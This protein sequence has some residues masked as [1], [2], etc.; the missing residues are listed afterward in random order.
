MQVDT[1][2]I[3]PFVDGTKETLAT[4]CSFTATAGKP[5]LKKSGPTIEIDIA[6]VIGLTS[7]AFRGSITISFPEKVF[8]SIMGAM[9]GETYDKITD[10]I[11]DGAAELMNIIFGHAKRVLN[12]RGHDIDKAIPTIARGQSLKLSSLTKSEVVVMPFTI[13][14][15]TFYIEVAID[16]ETAAKAA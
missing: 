2:F 16:R 10:E 9:L 7:S 15:G 13:E 6:G 8:L 3:K 4:L 12:A 11:E 5:F 1:S 14:P